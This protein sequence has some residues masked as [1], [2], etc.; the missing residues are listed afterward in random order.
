MSGSITCVSRDVLIYIAI[1]SHSL[2]LT[3]LMIFGV[4]NK[5]MAILPESFWY[6][7][8]TH[9]QTH[10]VSYSMLPKNLHGPK[11]WPTSTT[12]IKLIC[13]LAKVAMSSLHLQ[14][15]PGQIRFPLRS[16]SKYGSKNKL[17]IVTRKSSVLIKSRTD[18][19][20]LIES[21]LLQSE[22]KKSVR[23]LPRRMTPRRIKWW[24]SLCMFAWK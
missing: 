14:S 7:V 15:T 3:F 24:N 18:E 13:I 1:I 23:E 21:Q 8:D 16:I 12:I 19:N 22:M 17:F 11:L 20:E 10:R 6:D 9:T 5:R 4:R 2:L